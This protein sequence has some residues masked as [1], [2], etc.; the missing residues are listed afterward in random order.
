MEEILRWF[1]QDPVTLDHV[2]RAGGT[3]MLRRCIIHHAI[4][5]IAVAR[6]TAEVLERYWSENDDYVN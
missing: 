6:R 4:G 5:H 2:K 3:G 1:G